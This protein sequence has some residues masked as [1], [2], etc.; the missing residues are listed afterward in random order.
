MKA[1]KM[2]TTGLRQ[3]EVPAETCMST[4]YAIPG[5]IQIEHQK[6][7]DHA[8]SGHQETWTSKPTPLWIEAIGVLCSTLKGRSAVCA[9][10]CRSL[11]P[12]KRLV[13]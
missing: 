8:T 11:T 12:A 1:M 3:L 13:E 9:E 10:V 4:N 5:T 7:I 6:R 2:E